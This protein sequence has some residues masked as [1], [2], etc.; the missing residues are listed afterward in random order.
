M[1][2]SSA[3]TPDTLLHAANPFD[4]YD[5]PR[6]VSLSPDEEGIYDDP[7]DIVD[8][9]IYDYPPDVMEFGLPPPIAEDSRME[10]TKSKRS[11][12]TT[13]TG[14]YTATSRES[15]VSMSSEDS[16]RPRSFSSITPS[17]RP[18]MALSMSSDDYYHVSGVRGL[19]IA[20]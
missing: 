14:N 18:S 10:T 11:D 20:D 4:I 8:L 16:Y 6:P 12:R 17:T 1:P 13:V 9:E 2:E 7:L 15:T 5:I 3:G 19:M